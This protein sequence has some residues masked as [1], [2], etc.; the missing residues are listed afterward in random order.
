MIDLQAATQALTASFQTLW[1]NF[2][3]A[4]PTFVVALV[5]FSL[6]LLV[7]GALGSIATKL[8]R[9]T[10]LDALV[11]KAGAIIKLQTLGVTFNF[12]RTVGWIVQWFFVV[13]V[14]IAVADILNL[15]QVTDFLK[16][17][18]L[19]LPNV[20]VAV[21]ILTLGLILGKFVHDV[22]ERGMKSSN[23]P[24]AAGSVATLAQW[25]VVVFAIMA[26]LAQ[27]GIAARLIEIL[28][29]GLTLGVGLA[30]GLAFGL[31]GKEKAKAWLEKMS[32]RQ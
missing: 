20:V 28:F 13:V 24:A 16:S 25:A 4:V 2:I 3:T 19:Y 15:T 12:S 14:L 18:A 29:A 21:V 32:G 27:L 7:A 11:E 17:V 23:M 10:K 6:G 1:F 31:G 5:V 9:L 26:S 30:F 22:V 8:I